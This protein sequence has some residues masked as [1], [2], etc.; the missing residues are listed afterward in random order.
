MICGTDHLVEGDIRAS[1]PFRVSKDVIV[2]FRE[3]KILQ[4][5]TPCVYN[6]SDGLARIRTSYSRVRLMFL[7][8]R[9]YLGT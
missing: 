2:M 8:L 6:N 5:N 3:L 7:L 1:Y 4:L 9:W